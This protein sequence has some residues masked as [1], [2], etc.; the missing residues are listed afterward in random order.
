MNS[1]ENTTGIINASDALTKELKKSFEEFGIK[2]YRGDEEE[3]IP[4]EDILDFL[5]GDLKELPYI[6]LYVL[7]H[8]V[9]GCVYMEHFDYVYGKIVEG[10]VYKISNLFVLKEYRKMNIASK[11]L[12]RCEEIAKEN[13]VHILISDFSDSNVPS[14]NW[15]YK[16]GFEYVNTS[17]EVMKKI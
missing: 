5:S 17:I 7:N 9:I 6:L 14:K 11:L 10:G 2:M 12:K 4:K 8:K 15:H 16:N 3:N 1:N 13:H